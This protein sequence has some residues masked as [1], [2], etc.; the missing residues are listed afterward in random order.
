MLCE[1]FRDDIS[2]DVRRGHGQDFGVGEEAADLEDGFDDGE[3]FALFFF[4]VGGSRPPALPSTCC[5]CV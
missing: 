5:A 4:G 2:G 1:S 3:G